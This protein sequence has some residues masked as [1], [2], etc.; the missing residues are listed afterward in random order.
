MIANNRSCRL[1]WAFGVSSLLFVHLTAAQEQSPPAAASAAQE[2][3]AAPA[4]PV[5]IP[6]SDIPSRGDEVSADLRRIEA[7]L[8]PHYEVAALPTAS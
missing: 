3:A 2:P 8:E 4:E 6:S 7:L 1:G 5:A